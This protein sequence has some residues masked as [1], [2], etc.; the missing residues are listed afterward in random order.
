MHASPWRLTLLVAVVAIVVAGPAAPGLAAE[1]PP[2]K[3]G[4]GEAP[5]Q[6][7]KPPKEEPPAPGEGDK[8]EGVSLTTTP[9]A[10]TLEELKALL[11]AQQKKLE[12]Q[13]KLLKEQAGDIEARQ[14]EIAE[15]KLL[16]E[17]LTRR[18]DELQGEL[19]T[20]E[21]QKA[22]EERLKKVETTASKTPELPPDVVSAGD[23]PGSIRIPGTDA[24]I[25]FGGR[26][27]VA[28]V[29]TLDPLGS[30]DRFLTNSI[31]VNPTL[32]PD[33][34]K[35][36]NI[37]ANTT[38]FNFEMRTPTGAGQVRTFIEGDF[39]GA[40]NTFRLRHAY[41]QYHG[42]LFGQT[43]STFSDPAAS[44][45]DLDFEGVSS[46]NVVRQP[47]IR[48]NWLTTPNHSVAFAIETPKVDVTGGSGSDVFPD[49]V[50]RGI[51]KFKETGHVQVAGVLREIRATF[52]LDPDIFVTTYGWGLGVSG[53]VPF[54][55]FNLTDRFIFQLNGGR[56][57]GRYIND[58][59]SL[60]GQ[61]GVFDPATGDFEL[62]PVWG[63]FL[64]YEHMWKRWERVRD[65]NLRSSIIYSVVNVDNADFQPG[66]AYHRTQRLSANFIFSP[67]PRIDAGL[68]Y[69]WGT[70][71]NF[72]NQ[73]GE[74]RQLQFVIL[75]RF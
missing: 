32:T 45:E 72:D 5:A 6:E 19:P 30:K 25:K 61:D 36:T 43:W 57:V 66:D 65:M 69:I 59:N 13:E 33:E 26:V 49:V 71:R 11:D 35:Q 28:V 74:A 60:G 75:F 68:Q 8:T 37:N 29:S 41:G 50:G 24:A 9:P 52:N 4:S 18:V 67:I 48:Y 15:L 12:E 54:R 40:G 34:G 14:K 1:E 16:I 51:W 55:Y 42:L 7:A 53:V 22:I 31:P 44:H 63:W 27:R 38:R 73:R 23:F 70:R 2:P 17:S 3:P 56:G 46:D 21:T 58:L 10:P 64:D 20:V 39:F 62:L 47:Q